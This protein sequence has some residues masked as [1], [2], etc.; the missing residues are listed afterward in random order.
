MEGV[1]NPT[2]D[3]QEIIE[4]LR[5]L[6]VIVRTVMIIITHKTKNKS[7]GEYLLI[8][9]GIGVNRIRIKVIT[10][11]KIPVIDAG[12]TTPLQNLHPQLIKSQMNYTNSK[13]T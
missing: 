12:I 10:T 1:I 7:E 6:I 5:N 9:K 8:E 13:T 4:V 3:T 11:E 2:I